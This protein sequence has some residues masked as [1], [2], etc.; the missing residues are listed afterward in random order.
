MLSLIT[1]LM[2]VVA[3]ETEAAKPATKPTIAKLLRMLFMILLLILLG[4]NVYLNKRID[5]SSPSR[6]D[7][8]KFRS[9]PEHS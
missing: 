1:P 8:S 9:A 2:V 5:W 6:S 4:I 3:A 7:E